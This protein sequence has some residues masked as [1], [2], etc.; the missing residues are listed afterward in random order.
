MTIDDLYGQHRAGGHAHYHLPT[1]VIL[2]IFFPI[3]INESENYY[4]QTGRLSA[5]DV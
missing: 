3:D 5:A 4:A 1:A 2:T